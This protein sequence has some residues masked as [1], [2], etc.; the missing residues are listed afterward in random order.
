MTAQ[1]DL[2]EMPVTVP[3]DFGCCYPNRTNIYLQHDIGLNGTCTR[4]GKSFRNQPI[5]KP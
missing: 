5:R 3:P 2:I 4:C 1:P